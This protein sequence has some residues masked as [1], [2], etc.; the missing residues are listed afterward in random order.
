MELDQDCIQWQALVSLLLL[1]FK[2]TIP[3]LFVFVPVAVSGLAVS[4]LAVGP[5]AHGFKSG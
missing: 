5:K 2:I 3:E 1:Y 4:M